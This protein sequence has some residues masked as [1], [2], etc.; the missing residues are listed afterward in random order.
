MEDIEIIYQSLRTAVEMSLGRKM[1]APR[2]FDFLAS[3]AQ[4]ITK[5]YV[6]AITFKRFWGY[7]GESNKH[8]PRLMTL[9]I[10]TQ[11]AGYS[12]WQTY[13]ME[14]RGM[15]TAQSGLIP[16]HTLF[17]NSLKDGTHI[18]L[19]WNPNR[20]VIIRHNGYEVFTVV[21]SINSK[22]NVGDTFRCGQI[23]E[24][25]AMF[26]EGLVHEGEK[27]ACYVCGSEDGVRYTL[28]EDFGE[29]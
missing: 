15:G 25:Q 18:E 1:L 16:N 11:L 7:L 4:N 28:L 13:Y 24:G 29:R 8:K 6:S 22:L 21:E 20:T 9:N 10:L 5:Q 2:D 23:V 19:K 3:Q 27:H 12:N 26:L 17:T 14:A